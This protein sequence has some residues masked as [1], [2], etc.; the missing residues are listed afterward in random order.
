[1]GI[2]FGLPTPKFL[3]KL[4]AFVI[5][6]EP[7]LILKSRFVSPKRLLDQGFQFTFKDIQSALNDLK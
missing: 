5:R 1:V 4:G 3:L 7:E 6:T 2:S